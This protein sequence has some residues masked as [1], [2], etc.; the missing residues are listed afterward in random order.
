MRQITGCAR[1]GAQSR[2]TEGL[3]YCS[4]TCSLLQGR[5]E[6][7]PGAKCPALGLSWG[8]A[9]HLGNGPRCRKSWASPQPWAGFMA[10][11][12]GNEQFCHQCIPSLT[13]PGQSPP[14]TSLSWLPRDSFK[15]RRCH[16]PCHRARWAAVAAA[17]SC[18]WEREMRQRGDQHPPPPPRSANARRRALMRQHD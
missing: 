16:R 8:N 9:P 2:A 18:C 13:Q 11:Q 1:R 6:T 12:M 4:R 14:Q 3:K 17:R 10:V 15:T 7:A 5:K